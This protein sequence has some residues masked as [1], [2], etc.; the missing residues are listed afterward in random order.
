MD[1][2]LV[3]NANAASRKQA[4]TLKIIGQ[5]CLLIVGLGW[6]SEAASADVTVGEPQ[7]IQ[8]KVDLGTNPAKMTGNVEIKNEYLWLNNGVG[9]NVLRL[10]YT[11]PFGPNK[12]WS[13]K[14]TLP[15]ASLYGVPG[16]PTS[17]GDVGLK[18]THVF[19]VAKTHAWA[20][21]AEVLLNTA[22]QGLGYGQNAMKLQAFYVRFLKGGA[23]FAPTLVH[24][25]GLENSSGQAELNITT[26]DF[27]YVPKLADQK[28]LLTLDPSVT[29]DWANDHAY[30]GACCDGWPRGGRGIWR[31]LHRV[32]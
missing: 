19:S 6:L 10:G 32:H 4:Y 13:L 24:T 28:T 21:T 22:D 20:G 12:D 29:Y 9:S 18:L 25:F 2:S 17:V 16:D 30:G 8:K 15:V 14:V 31:H 11:M 27:Y 1:P 23:L 26:T 7:E 5:V 3:R